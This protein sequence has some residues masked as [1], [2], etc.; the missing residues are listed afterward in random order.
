MKADPYRWDLFILALSMFQYVSQDDPTSWYQIAG[1]FPPSITHPNRWSH[2]VNVYHCGLLCLGIHGVPYDSWNGVEAA[3][4]ANQS[5]YCPHS[6]VLFPTW[7]R[8]YLAL[9]EVGSY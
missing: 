4:G 6:S 2:D 7:H 8:P 5:G 9:F 3:A 1:R